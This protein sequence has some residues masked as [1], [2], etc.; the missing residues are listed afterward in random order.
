M[1]PMSTQPTFSL[2]QALR[3]SLVLAA[4]ATAQALTALEQHLETFVS[5]GEHGGFVCET[6]H[7]SDASLRLER[8]PVRDPLI[9]QFVLHARMFDL[10]A[11]QILN[12]LMNSFSDK[13]HK[14][15][16]VR[17]D[18]LSVAQGPKEINIP[19]LSMTTAHELYP[20]RSSLGRIRLCEEDPYDYNKSRRC[21]IEFGYE[22][23]DSIVKKCECYIQD[24][25]FLMEAGA[26]SPPLRPASSAS[27]LLDTLS[28]YD[29]E[30]LEIVFS[31]FDATE[32]S[33]NVLI[34]MLEYFAAQE[35]PIAA[36][37]IE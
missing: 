23:S 2:N 15:E 28:P 30:S 37:T 9:P 29:S 36:L 24:W 10:R 22:A 25:L 33:W 5:V 3:V 8:L 31:V 35:A 11:L 20:Q 13:V 18:D 19:S 34:N 16:R 14:I 32:E 26:F 6:A 17:I 12:N 4:E 21:V 1:T 7:P 27:V